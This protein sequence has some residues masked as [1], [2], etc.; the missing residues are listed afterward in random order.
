MAAQITHILA[1]E[2]ALEL[3]LGPGHEARGSFDF[4]CQ[5]PDIFYHN[6]RTKPSG[7][8]FGALAHRRR[9]GSLVAGAASSLP[10]GER[11][12]DS[13]AGAYL[14]GLATHA[15]IDRATHPFIVFFSGWSD[16]ADPGSLRRRGCHPFLERILDLALLD[17]ALGMKPR[18]FGLASRMRLPEGADLVAPWAAGLRAAYP[19][20]TAGDALLEARIANALSDARHF[21]EITDPA[22]TA[23]GGRGDER[24]ARL[25][26]EEWRRLVSLVYPESL[27]AGMDPMNE[28]GAEWQ[29]PAGDGRSS[30]ASYPEL[31]EEGTREALR[32]IRLVIEYWEGD[33]PAAEL[34]AELGEGG[35]ALCDREGG[36]VP[37][38]VCRPLPLPEAM[39]AEYAARVDLSSRDRYDAS[40]EHEGQGR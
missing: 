9:Y 34:A 25:G 38:R 17:R 11:R 20:A 10:E 36:A 3:A 39:E 33:L 13:L 37:P 6:Q 32:S 12:P 8:H 30:R 40:H 35:L 31:V 27:P 29:H 7:L 23:P 19:R 18:D 26:N 14:L 15:A 22:A 16:P 4:G 24:L 2:R 28:A 21:Y 1:G 5:G